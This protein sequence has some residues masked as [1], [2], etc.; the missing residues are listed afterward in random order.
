MSSEE[1]AIVVLGATGNQGAAVVKYL[2]AL[3]TQSVY[4]VTRDVNNPRS[5]QLAAVFGAKLLVGDFEKKDS[6]VAA[7][8]APGKPVIAFCVSTPSMA[9]TGFVANAEAEVRAPRPP[10]AV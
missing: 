4:A 5:M 9:G 7:F 1:A 6:L 3:N 10:R 2:N 8:Q